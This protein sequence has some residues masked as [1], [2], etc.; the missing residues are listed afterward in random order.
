MCSCFLC[1]FFLLTTLTF[2]QDLSTSCQLDASLNL[3][4]PALRFACN[5]QQTP[6]LIYCFANSKAWKFDGTGFITESIG[7]NADGQDGSHVIGDKAYK[8]K[9]HQT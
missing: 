3:P 8:N 4:D 7:F 1:V 9:W 5:F 2:A 6:D